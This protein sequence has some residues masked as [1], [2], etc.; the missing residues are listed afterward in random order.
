[1]VEALR[2]QVSYLKAVIQT[3]DRQLEPRTEELRRKDHII[4]ALTEGI[5]ELEAP[6]EPREAPLTPSEDHSEG[7]RG[8]RTIESVSPGDVGCLD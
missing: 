7:V 4:A 2:D 5:P 8:Y 3:R 6:S 1:M